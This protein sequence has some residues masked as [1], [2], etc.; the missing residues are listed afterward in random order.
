MLR[1]QFLGSAALLA[2]CL[3]HPAFAAGAY[4]S[5][6]ITIVVPFSAGG[7]VDVIGRL[8]AEKL[9]V[10]LK[11]S[12]LIENKPGASGMVGANTVV[13]AAPDGYTILFGSPGETSI[14]PLVYTKMQYSPERDLSPITLAV[15]VPNVLVA[16]PSLP[17]NNIKDLV[18]Y[19]HA[20]PGKLRYATS[21]VGNPQH[22]NGELLQSLAHIKMVHV[23]YKGA[24]GQLVDVA[25]GNVDLTFVAMSGALPF[26]Q[27]GKVKPIAITSAKRASFA[28]N[29]PAI[30]EYAPLSS[31]SLENWFGFFAPAKT[32][33][34]IQATLNAAITKVL[35]DPD[36]AAK[37]REQGGEPAPMTQVQFK[38]FVKEQ[39][40]MFA[41]IVDVAHIT[42]QD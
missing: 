21:G 11:A 20:H 28:P 31:Y 26:L 10:A 23:P 41:K 9:R 35:R 39:T 32:P 14:N 24:S 33:A 16:T 38:A 15:R 19:A 17:I 3:T 1:H 40:A 5:R 37:L 8:V 42:A 4:P 30:A 7:G 29:I 22:L 12:I 27:N 25:S 13:R 34:D 18:A 6:P 36:L 2:A